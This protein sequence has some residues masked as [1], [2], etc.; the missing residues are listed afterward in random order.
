MPLIKA[1][2]KIKAFFFLWFG[3]IAATV[4]SFTVRPVSWI[5]GQPSPLA[6][7]Y[8][9]QQ[10]LS[11]WMT[12]ERHPSSPVVRGPGI[13]GSFSCWFPA[14]KA[15]CGAGDLRHT[16]PCEDKKKCYLCIRLP[17]LTHPEDFMLTLADLQM[18]TIP[19][20]DIFYLFLPSPFMLR[21]SS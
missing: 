10:M 9:P 19:Q 16:G 18:R 3:Q 14:T 17:V 4:W 21:T 20:A 12:F 1:N 13:M 8:V 5:L 2:F 11:S 7:W 15:H 6:V